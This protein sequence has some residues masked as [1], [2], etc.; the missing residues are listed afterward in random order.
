MS[1]SGSEQIVQCIETEAIDRPLTDDE[2]AQKLK[3]HRETVT[4]LRHRLGI[5]NS[6][7]R[8]K[9]YFTESVAQYLDENESAE[10]DNVLGYFNEM[11]PSLPLDFIKDILEN[12]ENYCE[13]FEISRH[14]R[15][16]SDA[17]SG[18]IGSEKSLFRAVKQAKAA[19]LYPPFGLSTL[20]VGES[21][22]GKTSF[23]KRMYQY[24]LEQ[25]VLKKDAPYVTLNCAD[26]A[27]N[28]QL[29]LS[30]LYGYRK[31]A[32]T[33]ADQDSIGLVEKADGGILFL[34]EIHRLPVEGQEI[35]F[36]L[37]DS[38]HYRR[39][40]EGAMSRTANVLFLCA[41]TEDIHSHL[42]LSFR[43][44]IPMVIH[45]PSLE[46]RSVEEKIDLVHHFFQYECD[47]VNMNL[48]VDSKVLE[49]FALKKYSG[50]IG[51]MK[52]EIKVTC[53]NAYVENIARGAKDLHIGLNEILYSNFYA[54]AFSIDDRYIDRVKN[55]NRNRVF[56]PRSD[57]NG[58]KDNVS[59][60][61]TKSI[62]ALIERKNAE[63]QKLN[64]NQEQA[65]S[66]LWTYVQNMFSNLAAHSPEL[67]S[68][69]ESEMQNLLEPQLYQIV[70]AFVR[71]A[72][73][74]MD[75]SGSNL[76]NYLCIHLQ[77]MIQR[78]KYGQEIINPNLETIEEMYPDDFQNAEK[79]VQTVEAFYG[80]EVPKDELGFVTMYLKA[81]RT[82][83]SNANRIGLMI[84]SHGHVA[85]EMLNVIKKLLNVDFPV[86]IDM[87]FEENPFQIF[88]KTIE[89]SKVIDSGKGILYL[90][91]MGSL[92]N[93]GE[94]VEQKT[95][96][97]TRT[98][99]RVD[100]VTLIEAVRKVYMNEGTL[101]DIYYT[102]LN[103]RYALIQA[104]ATDS[105]K[106][107]AVVAACL[108]GTGMAR[109]IEDTLKRRFPNL[110]V[111]SIGILSTDLRKDIQNLGETYH[112]KAIV[113]TINPNIE[114][115][116]FL[117]YDETLLE[118]KY[119]ETLV[120][121]PTAY[122]QGSP[123]N[124]ELIYLKQRLSDKQKVLEFI[125]HHLF[126][127]SYVK[128]EY[129]QSLV[130][131]E[132]LGQTVARGGSA[133]PHGLPEHVIK[134]GILILTLAEPVVW[135]DQGHEVDVFVVPVLTKS[136]VAT[137]KKVFT[138]IR[139]DQWLEWIRKSEDASS[140]LTALLQV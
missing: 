73:E 120:S 77:E 6:R 95:G 109:H 118:S 45:V 133:M 33:G 44:R 50:N 111:L 60:Y 105:E 131:R 107:P 46:E 90:S 24:A 20:I 96:I 2:I 87:P 43:R 125:F 108:T 64:L 13:K 124:E 4:V 42:L 94:I 15:H 135:D 3:M 93:I 9:K 63:V 84:L 101:D 49:T 10:D 113:G 130:N 99:D 104:R 62:Y 58:A 8:R 66:V 14:S 92:I 70:S 65:R 11:Y 134:R 81:F 19:L 17:F 128:R 74:R 23:A 126:N 115:I 75:E 83:E 80:A 79:L 1:Q 5:L 51:Q 91:D 112:L 61:M 71:K 57:E 89:I 38:G 127:L 12:L 40:G 129:L 22:T 52:S 21:G 67:K 28:P 41:T 29:L 53:A 136:D 48:V 88:E 35:L 68:A 121:A 25:R 32:F 59:F 100:I 34:D 102:I 26:Y 97:K 55:K 140:L 137:T 18:I 76:I 122:A 114:G 39:L 72:Y 106:P 123:F 85:S 86:A 138:V 47:Q 139:S 27:D 110:T 31:G 7:E 69:S 117:M 116:P 54:G 78:V 119:F 36:S 82:T 30:I 16:L 37:L 103:N 132:T 56:V 98:L